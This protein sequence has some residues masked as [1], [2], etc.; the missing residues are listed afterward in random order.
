M[1][2]LTLQHARLGVRLRED[3]IRQLCSTWLL[4][5]ECGN[6]VQSIVGFPK[7][8]GKSFLHHVSSSYSFALWFSDAQDVFCH[9][10]FSACCFGS[11]VFEGLRCTSTFCC[12]LVLSKCLVVAGGGCVLGQCTLKGFKS[13]QPL[14]CQMVDLFSDP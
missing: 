10:F 11:C 6:L 4:C 5:H 3:V 2:Q 13:A 8:I 9:I 1:H 7:D 12:P 14:S